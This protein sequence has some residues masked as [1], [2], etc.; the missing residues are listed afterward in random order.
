MQKC[1]KLSP[2]YHGKISFPFKEISLTDKSF[3]KIFVKEILFKEI[4]LKELCLKEICFQEACAK[5]INQLCQFS[6]KLV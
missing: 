1:S 5:D 2:Y 6:L 3:K 4:L